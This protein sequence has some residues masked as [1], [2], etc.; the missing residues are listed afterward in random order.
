MRKASIAKPNADARLGL[1]DK[2]SILWE[3]LNCS[4]KELSGFLEA[5]DC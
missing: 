1:A 4:Q 2:G 5:L 3:F